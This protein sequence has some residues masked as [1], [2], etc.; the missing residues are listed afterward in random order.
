MYKLYKMNA[1]LGSVSKPTQSSTRFT[2]WI[3]IKFGN[4]KTLTLI[5]NDCSF[6]AFEFQLVSI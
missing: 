1:Q 5:S 4:R 6:K 2:N 3:L